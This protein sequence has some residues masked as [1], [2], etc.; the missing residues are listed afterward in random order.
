MNN[1]SVNKKNQKRNFIAMMFEGGVFFGGLSFVDPSMIVSVFIEMMTGNLALVGLTNSLRNASTQAAQIL[2]GLYADKIKHPKHFMV[3]IMILSRIP[4]FIM[5][6]AVLFL[7]DI[8]SAYVVAILISV[9]F[10]LDG[11]IMIPWL[12]YVSRA[13]VGKLRSSMM[14]FQHAIGSTLAFGFSYVIRWFLDNGTLSND[15]KFAY[16]FAI[17][18]FL[19]ISSAFIFLFTKVEG[20]KDV[21]KHDQSFSY[22]LKSMPRLA[23][24][25]KDFLDYIYVNMLGSVSIMMVGF[26]VVFVKNT[27]G[28]SLFQIGNM[29]IVQT[30]GSIIC[31]VVW[32]QISQH[33]GNRITIILSQ[34]MLIIVAILAII[35]ANSPIISKSSIWLVA[36]LGGVTISTR[37]YYFNYVIDIVRESQRTRYLM[38]DSIIKLPLAALPAIAGMLVKNVGYT[39][40]YSVVIVAAILTI[41]M[42]LR[43]KSTK[44]I[45]EMVVNR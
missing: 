38:I 10:I 34:V 15:H 11:S 40:I 37:V 24:K 20:K 44:Q 42:S 39:I 18:G 16:L 23:F 19:C 25:N 22:M 21:G 9:I 17:G 30:V 35:I 27:L 43:L 32:G 7:P 28:L 14:G 13:L 1:K 12:D 3:L 36:F 41:L 33:F 26:T 29:I 45:Q 31:G 8:P 5:A 4:P 6:G 2:S